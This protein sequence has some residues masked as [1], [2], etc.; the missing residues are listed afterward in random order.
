MKMTVQLVFFDGGRQLAQGLAHQAGLQAGQAVAHFAFDF[1]LGRER[2]DRV[3]HHQV[4]RA[5]AHQAVDDFERLLTGVGLGNQ[6]VLQVHAQVLRVLHVQRVFGVH[7]GASAA[8]LLHFGDDLQRQ[9]GLARGFRAVDFDDAATRQAAHAQGDVQTQRTGGYHLDVL[10][11]LAFAQA[12]D[13]A[14]A[15][16]FLDL[17]QGSLQG[18]G[19]FAVHVA[20][21]N[22]LENQWF[23]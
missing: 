1:G 23:G 7:K 6:Q 5:R 20:H 8:E 15:E 13:G 22:L 18:L 10:D 19:F 2:S 3:D 21:G 14:L 11:L 9:R 16:L 4:H 17:G 12:H